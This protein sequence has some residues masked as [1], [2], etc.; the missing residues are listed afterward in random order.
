[1]SASRPMAASATPRAAETPPARCVAVAYSGGRDS[2]A[3]LH[4]TCVQALEQGLQVSALHVHHGLSERADGWLAHCRQ[5]CARWADRGWPVRLDWRRLD[6]R[7]AKG[8]STEEWARA[9]RYAALR[10][11][12]L[13]AGADL[14]LLAHHR[15]DQAETLLLQALRGAGA[16]GL[17]AMPARQW[18]EGLCWARPWLDRPREAVEAYLAL[19]D[20]DCVED[21]SNGDPRYARNRLR[22]AVWPALLA[23]F[24]QAETGLAQAA[25]WAQQ[26]LD[27]QREIAAEDLRQLLGVEGFDVSAWQALSPARGINALRAWLRLATGQAAPASLIERLRHEC[28]ASTAGSW[29]CAGGVL[30]LY[31]GRLRWQTGGA[32]GATPQTG[33]DRPSQTMNL[34][35]AG[36]HPQPDWGGVWHVESVLHDGVAATR[37]QDLTLRARSGGEQFQRSPKSVARRLKKAYQEAGI[38]AWQREGP[39]LFHGEQLLFAPGLGVDARMRAA[40]GEVQFSLRWEPMAR[41]A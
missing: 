14:L 8:Q 36:A 5:Q 1:M 16:A 33:G 23:A 28:A 30:R 34:G 21:D 20:L 32:V 24:P 13:A 38:P 40:A 4:A 12:A 22:L 41:P 17:A 11:M 18:R 10:E 27:L 37:L 9:G 6:G 15:R 3:L 25:G 7:P 29:P 19:H 35:F 2:T 31:R 39:L 26:A